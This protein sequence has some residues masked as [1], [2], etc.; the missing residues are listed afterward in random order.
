MLLTEGQMSDYKG[1][2]LMFEAMP[3]APVL[4]GERGYDAD[5]LRHALAARGMSIGAQK[6]PPI[7]VQ[8]GPPFQRSSTHGVARRGAVGVAAGDTV[9]RPSFTPCS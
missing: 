9:G 8:K 1:A 7:G 4:L 5:W 6:G 3:P 2:A